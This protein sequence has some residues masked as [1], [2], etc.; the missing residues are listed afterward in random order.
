[1]LVIL[2][3]N[4]LGV[5]A[6]GTALFAL[7]L[8][9]F[10]RG[11][12]VLFFLSSSALMVSKRVLLSIVLSKAREKGFNQK[13][14]IVVGTGQLAEKYTQNIGK[15]Q[16]VGYAV[17][18][19]FG[20]MRE[21]FKGHYLGGI[22]AIE[23]YINQTLV[24]EVIVAFEPDETNFIKPVITLCERTGVRVAV[25]PFYNDI[26]PSCPSIEV[27]GNVKLIYL[28]SIPLDNLGYA[29]IKR[30][31]DIL[32]SLLFLLLLSPLM[33]VAAVGI[34]L[35]SRGA[36]LF[37]QQRVGRNK[38][39]F[40]MYKF[41]SMRENAEQTTGWTTH[42]DTRRTRFG[43]ILR[44]LS[45]DEL[46]QL[47]N[48]LK[49]EM[50]LIGPRPE[51]PLYVEKFAKD[52]PLY[53]VKHQIR[54]GMTGWAQVNGYRGDTSIEKRIEYDIWYIENWRI[55]LDFKILLR[56]LLGAWINPETLT[57]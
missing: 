33:L 30:A 21:N 28:R 9:D 11:V 14:V 56:T 39:L 5:L 53:M 4:A 57:R 45:I 13:T 37:K 44:K 18:G 16:L 7:R 41:R 6:V 32:I 12:L 54:P 38:K 26:I 19:Y 17:L 42:D 49:G 29:F 55:S 31:S 23:P 1:V 36:V 27:L 10:S 43:R 24:D 47:F 25:I 34:K 48:V 20:T 22:E 15:E 3:A 46:P 2:E 40:W 50:S 52:I 35:T 8:L 51:I